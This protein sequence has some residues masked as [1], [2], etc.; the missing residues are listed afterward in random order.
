MAVNDLIRSNMDKKAILNP[1]VGK[2][3][4]S[5]DKIH[6]EENYI[7]ISNNQCFN[8]SYCFV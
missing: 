3:N 2:F 6:T 8:N 4:L 7:K 5:D 1:M